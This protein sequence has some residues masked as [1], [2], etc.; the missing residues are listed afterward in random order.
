MS[1]KITSFI[2]AERLLR[3]TK[4]VWIKIVTKY[5]YSLWRFLPIRYLLIAFHFTEPQPQLKQRKHFKNKMH[6]W[7]FLL[8]LLHD[9]DDSMITWTNKEKGEF[10]F[11]D[12]EQVAS[13]WGREH[14]RRGMTYDKLSRALRQY[15]NEGIIR[16]VRHW[17][18]L[19]VWEAIVN[20]SD[21]EQENCLNARYE[22]TTIFRRSS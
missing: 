21:I 9:N 10:K 19:F 15:Y 17:N 3:H 2:V 18:E 6:L 11:V 8:E 1:L 12:T 13:L 7:E 22:A 5:S 20:G 4:E 16:K 14:G